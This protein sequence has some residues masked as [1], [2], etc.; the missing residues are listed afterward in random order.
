V[1]HINAYLRILHL[2]PLFLGV[3]PQGSGK[4]L[5]LPVEFG[6]SLNFMLDYN[7]LF[8]L[9]LFYNEQRF[10]CSQ[11]TVRTIWEEIYKSS[12]LDQF[13]RNTMHEDFEQEHL[14]ALSSWVCGDVEWAR[15]VAWHTVDVVS[16]LK[17]FLL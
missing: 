12:G 4:Y 8:I 10:F 9:F 5:V 16:I 15:G 11:D 6:V 13:D 2:K 7:F 17:Y 3:H 1:Q 14:E